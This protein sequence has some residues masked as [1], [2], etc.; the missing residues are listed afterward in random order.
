[1]SRSVSL[2]APGLYRVPADP[3]ALVPIGTGVFQPPP[4]RMGS[5]NRDSTSH[6]SELY[7][8]ARDEA[9]DALRAEVAASAPLPAL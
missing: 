9:L 7:A 3:S 8:R 4:E 5:S 2:S 1:M 6:R